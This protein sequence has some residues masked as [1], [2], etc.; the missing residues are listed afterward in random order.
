MALFAQRAHLLV[1]VP[2]QAAA[3]Q[4]EPVLLPPL[5]EVGLG[6]LLFPQPALALAL[7]QVLAGDASLTDQGHGVLGHGEDWKGGQ[8]NP[9]VVSSQCGAFVVLVIIIEEIVFSRR[10]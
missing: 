5:G 2:V 10:P 4:N 6:V 1:P 9:Y 7:A 8:N 3:L